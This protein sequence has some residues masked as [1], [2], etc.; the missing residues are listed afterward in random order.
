M[1][2][3][4]TAISGVLNVT[5]PDAMLSMEK[6]LLWHGKRA[7]TAGNSLSGVNDISIGDG[8]NVIAAKPA[9]S[10]RKQIE[11]ENRGVFRVSTH[12]YDCLV[13]NNVL[14]YYMIYMS[15]I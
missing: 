11:K 6:L 13:E 4:L 15:C 1:I 7:V 8:Q 5:N 14:K 3:P 12:F 9:Q 2:E 10:A